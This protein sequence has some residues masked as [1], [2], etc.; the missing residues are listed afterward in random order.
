MNMFTLDA[1]AMINLATCTTPNGALCQDATLRPDN[2]PICGIFHNASNTAWVTLRGGGLFVVDAGATPMQIVGEYDRANIAGNGCGG[3]QTNGTIYINSGGATASNLYQFDL[4]SLPTSG[5]SASNPPNTPARTHVFNDDSDGRD[6]HGMTRMGSQLWAF[7]RGTN[8]V[9]RFDAASGT[10]LGTTSIAGFPGTPD[11][12]PDI[13]D[14]DPDGRFTYVAMRGP[15]P[16]SGDPHVSTGSTP[17]L[18]VLK[19]KDGQPKPIATVRITN[20]EAGGVE[21][22]D[23]HGLRVRRL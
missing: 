9:E 19:D 2:A 15:N 5:Y 1:A 16:L 17:G 12:T 7:D 21:R 23:G 10:H 4:Y 8:V 14:N 3:L 22:A 20:V 18:M 11:P 13:A 6:S